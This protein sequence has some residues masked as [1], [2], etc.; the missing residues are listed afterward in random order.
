MDALNIIRNDYYYLEQVLFYNIIV[1]DTV[2][3]VGIELQNDLHQSLF[4]WGIQHQIMNNNFI[5]H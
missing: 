2:G 5:K 1:V 4:A 3:N